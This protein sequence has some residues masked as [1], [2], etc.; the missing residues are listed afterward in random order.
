MGFHSDIEEV[1]WPG[2]TAFSKDMN[3]PV[4]TGFSG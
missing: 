4:A 1:D 2:Q 3:R